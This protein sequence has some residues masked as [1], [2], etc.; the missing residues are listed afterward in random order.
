MK[1]HERGVHTR[2]YLLY[3][4]FSG[5]DTVDRSFTPV[6]HG[7]AAT[8]LQQDLVLERLVLW[9]VAEETGSTMTN[10]IF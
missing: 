7:S 3:D 9:R 8:V 4:A 10:I 2:T 5:L 1:L 6:P